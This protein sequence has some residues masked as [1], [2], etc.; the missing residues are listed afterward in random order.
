M[1]PSTFVICPRCERAW[2][3][4]ENWHFD[5]Q[6]SMEICPDCSQQPYPLDYCDDYEDDEEYIVVTCNTCGGEIA[7]DWSTC[8]C[9]DDDEGDE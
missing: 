5:V 3:N 7:P 9:E 6:R 4:T 8:E 2:P 1:M